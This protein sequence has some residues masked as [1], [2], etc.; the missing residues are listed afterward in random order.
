MLI[1]THCHIHDTEFYA[2]DRSAVYDRARAADV[3]MICVGTS[4]QSSREAVNFASKYESTWATVGVHPHDSQHGW[5]E[6]G[7]I[8]AEKPAGIVG[9]GEI[10]LD[11]FYENSPREVQIQA[12]EQQ[13]QWARDYQ[14]PVSFHVRDSKPTVSGTVWDD[15]WPIFG[16]F[17]GV[18]G[19][20]HSY[21]DTLKNLDIALKN[22]LFIGINGIST[23]AKSGQE[24]WDRVPIEKMLL[25]TDAPFLTPVPFRGRV[26]EPAFVR[27]V[28]EYHAERRGL[29]L[30][31]LAR[32]TSANAMRLFAL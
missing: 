3:A 18:K 8:L 23:F 6:I 26:N 20:L 21:T 10:G 30:E 27:N 16:N 11:Y 22:D 24:V 17:T 14:L 7:A 32:V 31:H 29:T 25:E 28:A 4:Q 9:I 1:D 5:D 13:L 2:D 15:F 12:F 19:V